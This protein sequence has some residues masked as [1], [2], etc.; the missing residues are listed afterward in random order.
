MWKEH[1]HFGVYFWS[2]DF[3]VA[4]AGVFA[5]TKEKAYP[6]FNSFLPQAYWEERTKYASFPPPLKIIFWEL[7]LFSIP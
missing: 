3:Q 6:D 4:W 1:S 5:Q 7:I 2:R